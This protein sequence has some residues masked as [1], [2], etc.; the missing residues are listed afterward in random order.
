[1]ATSCCKH[2]SSDFP[3]ANP[4]QTTFAGVRDAFV[5]KINDAAPTPTPTPPPTSADISI[6]KTGSPNSL[7]TSGSQLTYTLNVNDGGPNPADN[8]NVNDPLPPGTAFVSLTTTQGSC[9]A[10]PPGGNAPPVNCSLGTINSG[11]SAIITIIVT[12]T[13]KPGSILSNTATVSST[14]FDPNLT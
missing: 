4:L 13:A 6:T 10:P 11:G 7:V 9:G 1:M 3:T 5:A 8:V 14:S 2:E 12:V